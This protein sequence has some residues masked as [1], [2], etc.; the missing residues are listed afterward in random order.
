MKICAVTTV[1]NEE[2]YIWYALRSVYDVI[3][4]HVIV[5]GA[6]CNGAP[7]ATKE[8]LST[9]NTEGEI[10]RFIEEFD[11]T[12][13]IL[14]DRIGYREWMTDLRN[15]YLARVP[16]DTDYILIVDGDHLHDPDE[17]LQV[18]QALEKHPNIL[19]VKAKLVFFFR[20]FKYI[21]EVGDNLKDTWGSYHFLHKY[22]SNIYYEGEVP[23][24]KEGPSIIP[25]KNPCW[26]K[27]SDIAGDE[28]YVILED[29]SFHFYHFGWVRT[30][31]RMNT[32]LLQRFRECI[33]LGKLTGKWIP[34]TPFKLM[35]TMSDMERLQW[36]YTYHKIWTN[37]FDTR[38]GEHVEEYK[39]PYPI[40]E[41]LR[42][43]PFWGKDLAWFGLDKAFVDLDEEDL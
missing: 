15:E 10:R 36:L 42:K 40:E 29:P 21:I 26:K 18:R 6:A 33:I 22:S 5:E 12:G 25:L 4:Y 17:L 11:H 27:E 13:K 32:H 41:E 16:K 38:C 37:S 9:D 7:E 39:G 30:F 19:S 8:G 23:R 1:L 20:T 24:W 3:D 14:Y 28:P 2:D 43:H 31:E 35:S 34:G